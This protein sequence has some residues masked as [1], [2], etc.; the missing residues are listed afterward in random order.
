M[1]PKKQQ[2]KA[3][4]Q[5]KQKAIEDKT[6]GM[7]NKNK[8]AKVQRYIQQVQNQA[9]GAD[10]RAGVYMASLKR[11]HLLTIPSRARRI[12][13]NLRNK[14]VMNLQNCLNRFKCLKRYHSELIPRQYS[15]FTLKEDTVKKV[16]SVNFLT[17]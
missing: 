4:K 17:I 14:S 15:V 3:E 9:K 5:K 12:K 10:Q 2:T 7:K 13:K 6:F 16:P 8:S 11:I 1:P